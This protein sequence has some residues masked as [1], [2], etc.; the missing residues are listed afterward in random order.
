M[1]VAVTLVAW[2]IITLQLVPFTLSQPLQ[3]PKAEAEVGA[4]VR[5]TA[6]PLTSGV[7]AQVPGTGCRSAGD[8]TSP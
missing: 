5:V 7:L 2:L 4:A 8:R 3:P 1:K 6:V